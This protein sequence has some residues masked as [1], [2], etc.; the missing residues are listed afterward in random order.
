MVHTK[1]CVARCGNTFGKAVLST[2]HMH[3]RATPYRFVTSDDADQ[4]MVIL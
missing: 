4:R 1:Y 2:V 3:I